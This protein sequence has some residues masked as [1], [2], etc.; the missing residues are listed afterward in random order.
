M[1]LTKRRLNPQK[2]NGAG[3]DYMP[4]PEG[5]PLNENDITVVSQTVYSRFYRHTG[6][7]DYKDP[8]C[9]NIREELEKRT[10]EVIDSLII[11]GFKV[12]PPL[13]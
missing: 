2:P 7:P 8:F 4:S 3:F 11:N 10:K 5:K 13:K 6:M 1:K 12:L 9:T